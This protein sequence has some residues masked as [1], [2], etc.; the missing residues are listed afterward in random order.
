MYDVQFISKKDGSLLVTCGD[1]GIF[2]YEWTN[3][4][5]PKLDELEETTTFETHDASRIITSSIS[6]SIAPSSMFQPHPNSSCPTQTTEI[7]SI[8]YDPILERLYGAA[9]DLF[10]GYI[11]DINTSAL[12]GTLGGTFITSS[13]SQ[14][15]YAANRKG[16]LD[17]LHTIKTVPNGTLVLSGGEDGQVGIWDGK[18]EAL[19][20]MISDPSTMKQSQGMT[21]YKS[22]TSGGSSLV[23]SSQVSSR[24]VSSIDVDDQGHWAVFGGGIEQYETSARLSSPRG[25]SSLD[26]TST[27]STGNSGGFVSMLN[28]QARMMSS[29]YLTR[30]NVHNVAYHDKEGTILSVGNEGVV[31]SWKRNLSAGR[32]GRSWLSSPSYYSIAVSPNAKTVAL[33]GVDSSLDCITS[34][35]TAKSFS[36][37]FE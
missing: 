34:G 4:L 29:C 30:E 18:Q 2:V 13:S 33:G 12:T 9:G 17:Y 26:A 31:S 28:L 25:G 23:L 7:N 21:Q 5:L 10:G 22:P 24:W 1:C 11:W 35:L 14:Q 16:H 3:I 37:K 20:E 27:S 19:V 32:I 6:M 8:S 15:Q 36:L